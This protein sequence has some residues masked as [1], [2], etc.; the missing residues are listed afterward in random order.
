[1]FNIA[2]GV[3]A[4]VPLQQGTHSLENP[5]S[6][7]SCCWVI[8][9]SWRLSIQSSADSTAERRVRISWSI[10]ACWSISK[11]V[12]VKRTSTVWAVWTE[13]TED[14]S[15]CGISRCNNYSRGNECNWVPKIPWTLKEDSA[16]LSAIMPLGSSHSLVTS[17]DTHTWLCLLTI[18]TIVRFS[19]VIL[20]WV[21]KAAGIYGAFNKFLTIHYKRPGLSMGLPKTGMGER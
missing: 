20:R 21:N 1:M 17:T 8:N 10:W 16:L 5:G 6:Q 3:L 14:S 4:G 13:S 19:R 12:L 15:C 9:V 7:V 11:V 2:P 18:W